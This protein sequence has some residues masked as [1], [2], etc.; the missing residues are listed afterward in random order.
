MGVRGRKAVL[1]SGNA[2]LAPFAITA[3]NRPGQHW[4]NSRNSVECC[5][6]LLGGCTSRVHCVPDLVEAVLQEVAVGVE[7]H[8]GRGVAE[9]LLD[10]FDVGPEAMA[11]LAAVCRS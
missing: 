1:T 4:G 6:A 2:A 3:R 11:R 7:R 10:H 9:H 8:R 5:P